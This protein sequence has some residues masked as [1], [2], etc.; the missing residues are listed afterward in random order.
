VDANLPLHLVVVERGQLHAVVHLERHLGVAWWEG[1]GAGSTRAQSDNAAIVEPCG[2]VG[3]CVG[4]RGTTLPLHGTEEG[5]CATEAGAAATCGQGCGASLHVCTGVAS[6]KDP[7]SKGMCTRGHVSPAPPLLCRWPG[8]RWRRSRPP[9]S[10][11][12]Q[13]GP[14][15][16]GRGGAGA[17]GGWGGGGQQSG[18]HHPSRRVW[19]ERV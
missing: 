12:T 15:T 13:T 18:G 14:Q 8:A 9:A 5:P 3:T 17:G 7:S 6:N 19:W 2:V 16:W 1:G 4:G 11:P 10:W